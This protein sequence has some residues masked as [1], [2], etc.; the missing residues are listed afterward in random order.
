MK[1]V[2]FPGRTRGGAAGQHSEALGTKTASGIAQTPVCRPHAPAGGA[3]IAGLCLLSDPLPSR[4]KGKT[5]LHG[6]L[7]LFPMRRCAVTFGG[8]TPDVAGTR[9]AL[10]EVLRALPQAIGQF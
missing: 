9:A 5:R 8:C 4:R 2:R 7:S 3:V 1:P 10:G 6:H